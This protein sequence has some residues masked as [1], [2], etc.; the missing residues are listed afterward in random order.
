[1]KS[2]HLVERITFQSVNGGVKIY[3]RIYF[4]LF[5]TSKN[6]QV[7]NCSLLRTTLLFLV[8]QEYIR[9]IFF[10]KPTSDMSKNFLKICSLTN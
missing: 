5:I 8:Y 1:M 4:G 7:N 9:A 3:I 2:V 10:E 6:V